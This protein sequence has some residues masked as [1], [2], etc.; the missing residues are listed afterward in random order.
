MSSWCSGPGVESI[1]LGALLALVNAFSIAVTTVIVKSLT[2]TES[3]A[4]IVTYMAL[5]QSALSLV[6]ALFVWQWPSGQ[7]WVWL[8]LLAGAGTLGHLCFTRAFARAEVTEIPTIWTWI[9]GAVI[10]A[11]TAYITHREARRGR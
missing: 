2:R 10:F 8:V 9:G 3:P 1:S 5:L 7:T 11:S 6:P 4:A